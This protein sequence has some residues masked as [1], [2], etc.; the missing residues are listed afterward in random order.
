M[1]YRCHGQASLLLG[2]RTLYGVMPDWNPL[3]LSVYGHI[4]SLSL[5]KELITDSIWAYQRHN[6][7][8][9]NLRSFPLMSAYGLPYIDVRVSFNSFIPSKLDENIA[10]KLVNYYLENYHSILNS[11]TKLSLILSFHVSLLIYQ[12]GLK[13]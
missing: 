9:R 1:A 5:Y 10:G 6:Y 8:Y 12:I 3:K 2:D 11:T 4:L 13:N 7:G